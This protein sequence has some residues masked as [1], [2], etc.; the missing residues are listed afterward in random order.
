MTY[1]PAWYDTREAK[2]FT[3]G[4]SKIQVHSETLGPN[5]YQYYSSVIITLTLYSNPVPDQ[6]EMIDNITNTVLSAADKAKIEIAAM[7]VGA[8]AYD[9]TLH[10]FHISAN[11]TI[12]WLM[13]RTY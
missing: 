9:N 12:N 6:A 11:F 4:I 7:E 8:L 13:K 10:R 2:F 5:C 3:F 1:D